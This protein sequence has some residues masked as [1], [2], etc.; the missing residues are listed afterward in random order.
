MEELVYQTI[1]D[2]MDEGVYFVDR[3][4][5]ITFWNPGAERITGYS[6]QEVIGH[7]C[8]EGILRHVT[9][10]GHQLCIAG[11]P[12][13]AVMQDGNA[14]SATVYLHHKAGHRIPVTVKG[15]A[16]RNAD[17][18]IVGSV[19]LFHPRTATRFADPDGR[20]RA[21]DAYVDVL[22]GIGNR[23]FGESN[24]EPII[25]AVRANVTSL[26]VL[27]IDVDH[28]KAVNDNFGHAMGDAALRMV[29]QNLANGLRAGDFPVRWGG[30]E[31]LALMPGAEQKSLEH[32]AERLRML[33]ENSWIQH[34]SEQVRVTVSVG[35]TL[36]TATDSA[37]D[38][39]DRADRLMYA[40]KKAGRNLVT[41]IAGQ[42]PRPAERPLRGTGVPWNELPTPTVMGAA[43]QAL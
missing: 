6:A 33:V 15:Q 5:T 8:S 17:G 4:R 20:S 24:I 23:R 3:Q 26:G 12:L 30:E 31:F 28:F 11:C 36:A 41:T 34:G 14:R 19:E 32:A 18:E 25:A 27:F 38:V 2:Q 16:I 35:A 7:S 1:V 13:A 37:A 42:M 43:E 29:G 10:S 9:D 40:S 39:L 22:T 21:D